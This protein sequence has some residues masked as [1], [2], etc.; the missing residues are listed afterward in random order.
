MFIRFL[1][2]MKWFRFRFRHTTVW[3]AWCREWWCWVWRAWSSIRLAWCWIW[4]AWRSIWLAWGT[5]ATRWCRWSIAL[6]WEWSYLNGW[7]CVFQ[8]NSNNTTATVTWHTITWRWN[9]IA[10]WWSL[11]TWWL[12]FFT[13]QNLTNL[14]QQLWINLSSFICIITTTETATESARWI[15][16]G[17]I[18]TGWESTRWWTVIA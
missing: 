11:N 3:W 5:V 9:A 17:W 12:A 14:F 15:S 13:Q 10:W 1:F 2:K 6:L 4:W 7:D 16:T 18:S 8:L